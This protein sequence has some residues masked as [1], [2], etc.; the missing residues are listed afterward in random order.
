MI[1]VI[2]M[3]MIGMATTFEDR[4]TQGLFMTGLVSAKL[5]FNAVLIVATFVVEARSKC[6]RHWAKKH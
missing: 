6:K 5:L 2:G 1:G 3:C 4:E